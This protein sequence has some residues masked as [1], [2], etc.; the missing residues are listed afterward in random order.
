MSPAFHMCHGDDAHL[1]ESGRS[2]LSHVLATARS[3]HGV[4]GV[5]D[6]ANQLSGTTLVPCSQGLRSPLGPGAGMAQT[7]PFSIR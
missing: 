6:G 7:K 1:H 2:P 3:P 5:Y 4:W